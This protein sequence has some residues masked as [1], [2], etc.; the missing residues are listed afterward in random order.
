MENEL[1]LINKKW[2]LN[3]LLNKFPSSFCPDQYVWPFTTSGHYCTKSG[4]KSLY[5]MHKCNYPLILFGLDLQRPQSMKHGLE[6][7]SAGTY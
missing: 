4:Y 5:D 3:E 1:R 7:G 6:S 2:I